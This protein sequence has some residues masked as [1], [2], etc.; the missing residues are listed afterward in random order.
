MRRLTLAVGAF[1][2][3]AGTVPAW[4]AA[5]AAPDPARAAGT[6]P[7]G[8]AAQKIA[9]EPCFE[10]PPGGDGDD[11]EAPPSLPPFMKRMDCGTYAAP[12]DWKNPGGK[13][14]EIA[15]SRLRAA[16]GHARGAVLINPGGP[17]AS[18]IDMPLA[19]ATDQKGNP[20]ALGKDL[21]LVGFDVRG[22]GASDS[23]TCDGKYYGSTLDPRDRRAKNVERLLAAAKKN[24]AACRSKL[25][26]YVTTA[27][28]VR[29]IDLLRSLLGQDRIHWLGYSAG[30]WLGAQYAAVFPKHAGRFVLDSNT[31]VTGTWQGLTGL[32]A[33]GFER[34]FSSDFTA[35]AAAHDKRFK[36]GRSKAQVRRTFE[37]VRKAI[38]KDPL[39]LLGGGDLHASDLDAYAASAMYSKWSFPQLADDL[40]VLRRY[41][42]VK[43]RSTALGGGVPAD[44]AAVAKRVHAAPAPHFSG[45]SVYYDSEYATFTAVTC[46]DTKF[47]GTV[48]ANVARSAKLGK[49]YPLIGYSTISD[50]CQ[51]WKRPAGAL[52]LRK[53]TG[54]G[55]PPVLMVQ[56]TH[57][58][59]TPYEGAVRTHRALAG[60]R[61]LTVKREGDHGLYASGL[62]C[63][64][65][66]VDAYLI[67][68]VLPKGDTSC[69]A[70]SLNSVLGDGSEP[71]M[72][73]MGAKAYGLASLPADPI[74][75]AAVL[76]K[77]FGLKS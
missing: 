25:A 49:K 41:T 74:A 13:K 33:K 17:G 75:R 71:P 63:V 76:A 54:K 57:D 34:R 27:Q 26:A 47:T 53:P 37:G 20:S 28:T 2:L 1:A 42:G 23:I 8:L 59:A 38:A 16:S 66:A 4:T 70:P 62:A 58:P 77:H 69:T 22:T 36:L 31:D 11:G 3:I 5:S 19:F 9:W 65:K 43:V 40:R 67:N 60:S 45:P 32:Q 6:V 35:W 68:G 72:V 24:A 12:L 73:E 56:S 51:Y 48:K 15:V 21:D 44:L 61:L 64:D 10:E 7:A 52:A 14:I 50:P 18:G 46:N 29:D 39:P 30:T 55:A